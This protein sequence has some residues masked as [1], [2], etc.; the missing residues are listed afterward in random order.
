M[1]WCGANHLP[2]EAVLR[3]ACLWSMTIGAY[4]RDVDYAGF[5]LMRCVHSPGP[6][7]LWFGS[8]PKK[9][10][11]IPPK[12]EDMGTSVRFWALVFGK[13]IILGDEGNRNRPNPT[14]I[15]SFANTVFGPILGPIF[16]EV[17]FFFLGGGGI[18]TGQT[19]P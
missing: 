10:N 16:L 17:I 2:L 4:I 5:L 11:P 19:Q 3:G 18:E 15:G 7:E 1:A 14:I 6:T 8:K 12:M 9:A 13:L